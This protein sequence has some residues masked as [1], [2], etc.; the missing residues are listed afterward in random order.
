MRE[1][2]RPSRELLL[3]LLIVCIVMAILFITG[4]SQ[5]TSFYSTERNC[6]IVEQQDS[7]FNCY[8]NYAAYAANERFNL[9]HA[10]QRFNALRLEAQKKEK[11]IKSLDKSNIKI[12][13]GS[14]KEDYLKK[15]ALKQIREKNQ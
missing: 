1:T 2:D 3:F 10:K 9:D 5:E 8:K 14:T 12:Y 11:I 13:P 4:C 6:L 7:T 15:Q